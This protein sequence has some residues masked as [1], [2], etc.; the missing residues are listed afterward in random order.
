V[1]EGI[2]VI[3]SLNPNSR[4]H[5]ALRVGYPNAFDRQMAK[6]D[7]RDKLGGDIMIHGSDASVGCLAM[8]DE[9]A[10]D[11]F[12][13]AADVGIEKVK[14]ILTPSDFRTAK[15]SVREG[16]PKWSGELYRAI[17]QELNEM[18]RQSVAVTK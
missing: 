4:F 15:I 16:S 14:V 7:G 10:E 3:E 2:Y 12:V 13:L 6:L 11:F 5:L 18:P 9:A 1:P 8:G 17:A